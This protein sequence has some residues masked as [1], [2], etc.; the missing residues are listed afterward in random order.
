M[1]SM[2]S[3]RLEIKEENPQPRPSSS[4]VDSSSKPGACSQTNTPNIPQSGLVSAPSSLTSS[5]AASLPVSLVTSVPTAA[6][7]FPYTPYYPHLRPIQLDPM[8][9]TLSPQII[10]YAAAPP[11]YIHPTQLGYRMSV[12][13]ADRKS[14]DSVDALRG[15]AIVPGGGYAQ[16]HKIHELHEKGRAN[17]ET[18]SSTT[19]KIG[20]G[21]NPPGP[22]TPG[23]PQDK[24][25][26]KQREYSSSPPT[27]RHV[28]THHHTHVM[29]GFPTLYTPDAYSKF[30]T[31][32]KFSKQA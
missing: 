15:D 30:L 16:V 20:G 10:G 18:R 29:S 9:R 13:E 12:V 5:V 7:A 19:A 2:D 24:N 25:K 31:S 1:E 32:T 3:K 28:H 27:Q 14:P 22:S 11:G 17:S 21:D 6:A 26:E 23:P 4:S 8:Y